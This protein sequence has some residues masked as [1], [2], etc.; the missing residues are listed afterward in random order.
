MGALRRIAIG[1]LTHPAAARLFRPLMRDQV[2]ILM[3]HRFTDPARG[4]VGHDPAAL[5]AGLGWLRRERFPILSLDQLL[6]GVTEGRLPS[7]GVVLTIDDGYVEQA[8]VG[9]PIFA[10]F[11]APVTTFLTSGFLDRQLWFWW[12]RIEY[13]FRHARR[14]E[15]RLQLAEQSVAYQWQSPMERDRAQADLTHRCKRAPDA[16]K[17]AAIG[18]L[19]VALEVELPDAAPEAYAPMTW[20]QARAA[21]RG[22]MTFGPHTETHPIL[23]MTPDAQ[24]ARELDHPWRR[25]DQELA[26]PVPVFCYP[27]GGPGDFGPREIATLRQL[28]IRGAVIGSPGFESA[29]RFRSTTDAPYLMPR[30]AWPEDRPNLVQYVSGLERFKDRLRAGRN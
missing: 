23:S 9:A 14:S 4:T 21:E 7:A 19:A 28:G 10:E 24:S 20:D 18:R 15:V 8:T 26:H 30:F 2:T 13:A 27:N 29:A 6:T 5:R 11:D 1:T 22:G 16:E 17:H 12:D 25:L 3:L